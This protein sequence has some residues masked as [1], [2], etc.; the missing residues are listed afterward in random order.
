MKA[1]NCAT[2]KRR[3]KN[4]KKQHSKRKQLNSPNT[5]LRFKKN[6]QAKYGLGK[7]GEKGKRENGGEHK[8]DR[9]RHIHSPRSHF[10]GL[11][12]TLK[13]LKSLGRGPRGE[14]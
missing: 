8:R 3:G 4:E 6:T 14:R 1:E 12:R 10:L 11:P 5:S 7:G 9:V 13:R 2:G